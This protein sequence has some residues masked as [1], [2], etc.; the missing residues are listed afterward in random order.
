MMNNLCS[1]MN[2]S[3][4]QFPIKVFKVDDSPNRGTSLKSRPFSKKL[5]NFLYGTIN[6]RDSSEQTNYIKKFTNYKFFQ[7]VLQ[8]KLRRF[9]I[10]QRKIE[11][12]AN[13][14][15]NFQMSIL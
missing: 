1:K 8:Y 3:M 11:Q 4:N 10:Y 13:T 5:K 14:K 12:Q 7:D 9:V 2:H 6:K 15:I